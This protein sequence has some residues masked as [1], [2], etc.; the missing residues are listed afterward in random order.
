MSLSHSPTHSP[1]HSHGPFTHS[2]KKKKGKK[3][4]KKKKSCSL[5]HAR[6]HF[7]SWLQAFRR[8]KRVFSSPESSSQFLMSSPAPAESSERLRAPGSV[9]EDSTLENSEDPPE[10]VTRDRLGILPSSDEA[11]SSDESS[12]PGYLSQ[13]DR[14]DREAV[15]E[16]AEAV[17]ALTYS[18]RRGSARG[19]AQQAE[20][21][22]PSRAG[23]MQQAE[24]FD[25]VRPRLSQVQMQHGDRARANNRAVWRE[26]WTREEAGGQPERKRNLLIIN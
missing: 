22:R 9:A 10:S 19:R 20:Q 26:T 7:A 24:A 6:T 13:E 2:W 14:L 8:S 17:L 23:P 5:T 21:S 4:K 18:R 3:K 16:D 1:T 15:I 25:P 12:D 11:A